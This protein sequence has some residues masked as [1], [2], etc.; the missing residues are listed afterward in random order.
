M[1]AQDGAKRNP[2]YSQPKGLSRVA[3][4]GFFAVPARV[5]RP[6]GTRIDNGGPAWTEGVAVRRLTP[7]F[8]AESRVN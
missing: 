1:T 7:P 6:E 8:S 5:V 3:T 2:G 4:T